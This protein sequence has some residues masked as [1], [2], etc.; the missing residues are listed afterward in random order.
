MTRLL[1]N[2]PEVCEFVAR[3][4]G[5]EGFTAHSSIGLVKSREKCWEIVLGVVYD[6]YNGAAI[7]MHVAARGQRWLTRKLLRYAFWYPF[8]QLKVR[9][10][11]GMVSAANTACRRFAEH[12]GFT[13]EAVLKDAHP[14]GDMCVYRMLRKECRYI[15]G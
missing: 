14:E 2:N 9:R 15:N 3:Q 10:V 12:L 13:L 11:T 8:C 7:S 1:I 6:D 5:A 4:T